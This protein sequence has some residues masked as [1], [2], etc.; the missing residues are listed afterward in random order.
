MTGTRPE[1]TPPAREPSTRG[2]FTRAVIGAEIAVFAG[3]S[4]VV[5]VG[6]LA[7]GAVQGPNGAIIAAV[8]GALLGVALRGFGDWPA[9]SLAGGVGGAIGGFFAVAAAEQSPPGS[10]EWAVRGGLLGA[11]FGVP[12]AAVVAIAVGVIVTLVRP[13]A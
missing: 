1:T 11:A 10:V 2:R 5:I 3:L 6:M 7:W 8:V 13:R 9:R 4:A 12:I